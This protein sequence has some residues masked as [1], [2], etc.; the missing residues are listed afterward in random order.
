MKRGITFSLKDIDL[1][2]CENDTLLIDIP[3]SK[4]FYN[5]H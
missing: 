1:E 2:F 4:G 5:N 3:Y